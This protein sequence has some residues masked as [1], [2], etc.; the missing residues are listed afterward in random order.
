M[1]DD[2][3]QVLVVTLVG[4]LIDPDPGQAGEPV[5]QRLDVGPDPGDD[6]PH[7]APRDPHQL[8]DRGLGALGRQPGDQVVEAE[9]VTR[10][11]PSPRHRL[12]RDPVRQTAHPGRLRLQPDRDRA[13]IQAP[14]PP[15]ALAPVIAPAPPA[16]SVRLLPRPH[17]GDQHLLDRVELDPLHDRLLHAQQGTP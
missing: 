8:R 6:R 14:P 9:G 13:Q 17:T 12:H 5:M 1:V 3:R 16:A 15:R 11:V 10:A 7:R 2:D 4:D